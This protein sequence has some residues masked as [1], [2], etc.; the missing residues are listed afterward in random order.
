MESWSAL[1][2][3]ELEYSAGVVF[4]AN[5]GAP[6]QTFHAAAGIRIFLTMNNGQLQLRL[7]SWDIQL[8]LHD[9]LADICQCHHD[10]APSIYDQHAQMNLR[11]VLDL[12][13]GLAEYEKLAHEVVATE[14]DIQCCSYLAN[15]HQPNA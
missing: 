4:G 10:K 14:Q 13:R 15:S 3:S 5:P 8:E 1:K 9:F 2:G 12:I 7:A 6:N 11:L